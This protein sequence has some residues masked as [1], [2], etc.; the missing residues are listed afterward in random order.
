[1]GAA[2]LRDPDRLVSILRS[3]VAGLP[4]SLSVSAKIRLLPEKEASINLVRKVLDTGIKALTIHCRTPEERPRD[5]AH[6]EWLPEIVAM[7]KVPIIANGDVFDRDDLARIWKRTG[8]SSV[9]IA[10][11][12]QWNPSIFRSQ[13]M[14]CPEVVTREYLQRA[15]QVD[16]QFSNT[17]YTVLQMWLDRPYSDKRLTARLQGTKAMAELCAIFSL[18][19]GRAVGPDVLLDGQDE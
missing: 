6:H 15:I 8:V 19:Y 16:N 13:G 7:A 17:K 10:R 1:M 4:S 11:G 14:L 9:M 5:A 3:L 18:P 2:L 12:A